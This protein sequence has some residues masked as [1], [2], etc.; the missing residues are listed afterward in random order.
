MDEN[1]SWRARLAKANINITHIDFANNIVYYD[2]AYRPYGGANPKWVKTLTALIW[3]GKDIDWEKTADRLREET[4][5][6]RK[7]LEG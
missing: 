7:E 2:F 6:L 4:L 3:V 1:L 5:S